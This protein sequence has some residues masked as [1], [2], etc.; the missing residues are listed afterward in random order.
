MIRPM[1]DGCPRGGRRW[2]V[3]FL[4]LLEK[5][6]LPGSRFLGDRDFDGHL[7][8]G[9]NVAW[10]DAGLCLPEPGVRIC[11]IRL[12]D[13]LH[14]EA[15]ETTIPDAVRRVRWVIASLATSATQRSYIL[16]RRPTGTP[17]YDRPLVLHAAPKAIKAG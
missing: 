4:A 6:A 3:S 5:L 15:H 14:R 1:P 16:P 8:L 17:C 7:H 13:W 11:R 9:A 10:G 12:S 2:K